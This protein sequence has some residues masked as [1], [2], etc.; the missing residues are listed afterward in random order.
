M[1]RTRAA[2]ARVDGGERSDDPH[3][4]P[5]GRA[6]PD[7]R[8]LGEGLPGSDRLRERRDAGRAPALSFDHL[9]RASAA[10]MIRLA[11]L[12][13]GS[14]PAAED[15]VHDAFVAVHQR[16]GQLDDPGAALRRTVVHGALRAQPR[17]PSEARAPAIVGEPPPTR[18]PA[19]DSMWD[20]IVRLPSDRRAVVVLRYWADLPHAEIAR[21]VGCRTATVGTRLHRALADLREQVAR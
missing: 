16:W 21:L 13:L 18:D 17:R 14:L 5:S 7:R 10:H 8:P 15:V 6:R 19:F 3:P 11:W 12:L 1:R 4:E 2:A 9:Y 20:A